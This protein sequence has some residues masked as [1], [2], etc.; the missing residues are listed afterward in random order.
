M[1]T[2][3][4]VRKIALAFPETSEKTSFGSSAWVVKDKFFVWER[5]LRK[6]DHAALKK[7]GLVAPT[8]PILGVRTGDLEM[9]DVLLQRD[10]R[11]YFTIPHFEGYPAVLVQL[12]KISLKEL[13]AVIA[14]AWLERA[15][16]R[17]AEAYL[18]KRKA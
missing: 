17:V 2:W 1:A 11:V 4:D 5:P 8:E 7:L 3:A 10:P 12:K 13:K 9:K 6:S 18:A 16:K 14:E 15:P